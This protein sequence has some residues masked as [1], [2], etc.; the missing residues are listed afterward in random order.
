MGK[1]PVCVHAHHDFLSISKWMSGQHFLS[2][3]VTT[4]CTPAYCP[5]HITVIWLVIWHIMWALSP[6]VLML[7]W[8]A[9]DVILEIILIFRILDERVFRDLA[10]LTLLLFSFWK[11][12]I[13]NCCTN[14]YSHIL[15]LI[16]HIS[17][18]ELE[19]ESDIL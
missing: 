16:F 18:R 15:R 6:V 19:G 13:K 4:S 7:H 2:R 9:L 17:H 3:M 14:T 1:S 10:T 5:V 11:I 8:L 12:I